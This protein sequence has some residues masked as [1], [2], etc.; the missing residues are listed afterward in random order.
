M[1][2]AR[3]AAQ[4]H[5]VPVGIF[6]SMLSHESGWDPHARSPVGARGIAQFM[7]DTARELG[8]NPNNPRQAIFAAA[9][10]LAGKIRHYG[11][12]KLALAS[13]NAGD[14]AVQKYGGVPPFA[15]TQ[16][17]VASI[18][19]DAG[20][21]K[22][23]GNQPISSTPRAPGMTIETPNAPDLK[24]VA[25]ENLSQISSQGGHYDPLFGL[26]NLVQ[27]ISEAGTTKTHVPGTPAARE[28]APAGD[29]S[30]YVRLASNADRN[31]VHT[32]APLKQF[33]GE[34]GSRLRR[35]L[36]IT[37]GSRHNEY[38]VDGNVSAH[39]TGRA[40]D[41]AMSGKALTRA[42]QQAL[43]LA[44]MPA[45]KAR[46]IRG[47]LFNIGGYQIIFNT[48]EGGNHFNHL[49]VGLRG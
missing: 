36:T 19:R 18:M 30:K 15:E 13:Y 44:G 45:A 31:G 34:L 40:G 42:G 10:Y 9:K 48:N 8:I 4:Q 38:T 37:T 16:H 2:W 24:G 7:P 3:Q 26:G 41:I 46:K 39:W 6:M 43:I 17:Y 23:S 20:H 35:P 27:A 28:A 49:H 47:G 12:V 32:V 14:G 22:G 21:Y 5:G 33:V 1:R 29:W 11:D 25:L